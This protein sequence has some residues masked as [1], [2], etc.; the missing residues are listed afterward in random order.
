MSLVVGISQKNKVWIGAD[1][2]F[3]H[4]WQYQIREKEKL[5][6]RD[7]MIIGVSGSGRVSQ[8]IKYKLE[9]PTHQKG[10]SSETYMATSFSECLR[11]L[12]RENGYITQKNGFDSFGASILVGYRGGLFH[13]E[14][15]FQVG[16]S[17]RGFD[18]VGIGRNEALAILTFASKL[19]MTPPERILKTMAAV[20]GVCMG[21]RRPFRIISSL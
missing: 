6:K 13:I 15:D 19:R 18:A 11:T 16:L 20:E 5:F 8:L 1:S 10:T 14:E 2:I 9:I 21:V 3:V 12:F 17:E 7:Q 4:D